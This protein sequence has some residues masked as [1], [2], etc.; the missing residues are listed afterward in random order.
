MRGEGLEMPTALQIEMRWR[1]RGWWLC[2]LGWAAFALSLVLPACRALVW[3]PGW[4]CLRIGWVTAANTLRG[5]D[6]T[7]PFLTAW[8]AAN[9]LMIASP[10]CVH[11]LRRDLRWLRRGA[12]LFAAA[13]LYAGYF[14]GYFVVRFGWRLGDLGP[15]YYAWVFSFGALAAGLFCLSRRRPRQAAR[16]SAPRAARMPEEL[17]ALHELERALRPD[18]ARKWAAPAEERPAAASPAIRLPGEPGA[19]AE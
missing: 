4:E 13:A 12:L 19:G 18:A 17:R 8:A 9:A 6:W 16:L 15:G 10:L 2:R 14:A 7:D 1:R 11:L 3:L 5:C